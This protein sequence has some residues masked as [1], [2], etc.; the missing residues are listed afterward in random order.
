M[1]EKYFK[2]KKN[3]ITYITACDPDCDTFIDIVK[4]LE[5]NGVD[6]LEIGVPFTDPMADGPTIQRA[7]ERVLKKKINL[8]MIFDTIKKIREFSNIPIVLFGY[9]NVFYNYNKEKLIKKFKEL[10]IQGFLCV[11]LPPDEDEEL[12]K[13]LKRI[14]V[15]IIYLITPTTTE[16]RIKFI[17]DKASG[18]IYYVSLTGTTGAREKLREDLENRVKLIKNN[19]DLPVAVGF[20]ISK[21]EHIEEISKFA[22]GIIVGSAIIKI[23]EQNIDD[24]KKLLAELSKFI[25]QLTSPLRS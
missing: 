13:D 21:K 8:D 1:L 15:D 14:G 12:I 10:N 20:G 3:F 23:I 9:Y 4:V 19:T 18:F 5:Q 25:K 7:F 17:I 6:I 22:D 24:K 16:E 11:D 2:N